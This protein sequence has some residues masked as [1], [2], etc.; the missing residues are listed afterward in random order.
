[1]GCSES[2]AAVLDRAELSE[3]VDQLEQ[4]VGQIVEHIVAQRDAVPD[5]RHRALSAR[6][7][8]M[9]ERVSAALDAAQ[10]R[11]TRRRC[12]RA[13]AAARRRLWRAQPM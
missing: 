5:A 9:D 7:D 6:C 4:V 11:C 1:M 10:R 2:R 3:R 12:A 8:A 13:S